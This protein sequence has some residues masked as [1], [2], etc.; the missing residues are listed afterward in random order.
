M[1]SRTREMFNL[2]NR[3]R[4]A[5]SFIFAACERRGWRIAVAVAATAS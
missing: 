4:S 3:F 1:N 5:K 2:R